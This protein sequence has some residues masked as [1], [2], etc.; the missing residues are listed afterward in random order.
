MRKFILI[1]GA[2]VGVII[3]ILAA[4]VF[5]AALNLDSIIAANRERILKIASDS[6]GRPVE[7]KQI[8]AHIGW[9]VM[10][11]V[12]GVKIA[13]DPAFSQLPFLQANDVYLQVEFVPLLAK[14]VKVT[15][16]ILDSPQIRLIRDRAGLLNASTIAKKPK[17]EAKPPSEAPSGERG[18]AAGL[19]AL[20]VKSLRIKNARLFYEDRQAGG[21]PISINALNLAV[22]N[23]SV[24]SPF[25]VALTLAALGDQ[26]NLDVSGQVGPLLH[27]GALNVNA[28]PLKLTAAVGPLALT[29][30]KS[31]AQL[32]RAIPP[33]LSI[34]G[35]LLVNAKADGTLNAIRFDAGSDLTGNAVAYSGILDKPSGVPFK[36]DATGARENGK[37]GVRLANLTL[38]SLELKASDITLDGGKVAARLDSNNFDLGGLAKVLTAAQKYSPTGNAAIHANVQLAGKQP[39]VTGTVTVANV[40]VAVPNAKVPPVGN[41]SGTIK[42]AG[43]TANLGPLTFN[44]GSGHAKLEAA[45]QSIQPLKAT[46]QFSAD[47]L[48]VGELV[49]SRQDLGE[50]LSQLA[51][52]GTLSRDGNAIAATTKVTSASGMVVNVPYNDFALAAAYSGD[53]LTIDSLKLNTFDGSVAASGVATLGTTPTFNL[54]LN[55]NNVDVRKALEAQKSKAAGTLRGNL[56]ANAQVAG[57][58]AGFDQIKPTLRGN[59]GG[60]LNN[61][62]LVGVNVVAQALNKVD[63]LPGI[64]VLVPTSVVNNHPELFKS[65]DTDIQQ[66]RLAFQI[67]GPRIITHDLTVTSLDYSLLGDG[68]FDMDKNI[69]LGARILMS[70]AFSKE[71]I[72]AKKNVEY[73][74][75]DKG[76][77]EIPLRVTGQLPKPAVLPDVTVL[78][79]RAAS[80]ALTNKLG[81]LLGKKKGGG[82]LG[83]LFG[84]GGGAASPTPQATP[85]NPVEKL[86]GLFP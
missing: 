7:A 80:H 63:N 60:A 62:K 65:N 39:S 20:T 9:G 57:S 46:Y 48:K 78:A 30:L 4:L 49:P 56:T 13:D 17:E 77:V 32:T 84:G 10:M 74:A 12:S 40:N 71:L 82:A 64:G 66:A 5:Y 15:S 35:P 55:A 1:T 70:P 19:A 52:N 86:K 37:V 11:D 33:A 73:L 81:E 23:F 36:F 27:D 67:Q 41:L 24:N 50:Q 58:G 54:K 22:D 25:D 79:Q 18:G 75:N 8:K 68:W 38:A 26:K 44:V 69:D 34:S 72:A 16:L 51:S 2:V 14:S 76:Q 3:A 59:G 21:S 83:G 47:T 61:G 6:V 43:N 42:M 28:I 85:F 29:Q 53:R 31:I 45:A